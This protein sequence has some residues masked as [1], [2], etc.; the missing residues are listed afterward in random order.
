[1]R[2]VITDVSVLFDIYHI[3]ALPEFFA[4]DFEICTTDF[5]RNEILQTLLSR[6]NKAKNAEAGFYINVDGSRHSVNTYF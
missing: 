6:S 5:V 4:L 2:L 1:M 3:R